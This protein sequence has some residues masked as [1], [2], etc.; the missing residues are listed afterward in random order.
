M[1]LLTDG[2]A[3]WGAKSCTLSKICHTYPAMMKLATVIPYQKKIKKYRNH[4]AHP[5]ISA[6]ISIFFTRNHQIL[7]YQEITF[8]EG[9]S[10]FKLIFLGLALGKN[11]KFYTSLSKGLR[12]KVRKILGLISTF[13]E[14]TGEK[15]IGGDF[16]PP[17]HPE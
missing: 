15:L 5:F 4:V 16:L 13:V 17:T 1:W 8:F 6:D 2:G 10:W 3:G 12:L 9:W 11:L 7:L 14:V